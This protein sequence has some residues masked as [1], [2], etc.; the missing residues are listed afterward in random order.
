MLS[1]SA[2]ALALSLLACAPHAQPGPES[3]PAQQPI[4]SACARDERATDAAALGLAVTTRFDARTR[5]RA[6]IQNQ[7]DKTR[8]VAPE[9]VS[10][11]VGPCAGYFAEC[12]TRRSWKSNEEPVLG[13]SLARGERLELAVDAGVSRPASACE[14]VSVI[15]IL[16][17]D[18]TRSCA[19]LGRFIA[20]RD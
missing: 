18:G 7:A 17:V 6:L 1:R 9:S 20:L 10:V 15:A 11:C 19:E 8:I 14:K 4:E 3:T 16:D 5:V 2:F 12:E 13:I